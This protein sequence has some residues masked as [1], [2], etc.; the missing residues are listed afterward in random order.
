MSRVLLLACVLCSGCERDQAPAAVVVTP[1]PAPAPVIEPALPEAD[2]AVAEPAPVD[3]LTELAALDQ[4]FRPAPANTHRFGPGGSHAHVAWYPG[5]AG[6]R[7]FVGVL[8]STGH[9]QV[10]AFLLEQADEVWALGRRHA[11]SRVDSE[12]CI[13]QLGPERS[14]SRTL[15]ESR[16]CGEAKVLDLEGDGDVEVLSRADGKVTLFRERGGAVNEVSGTDACA[17]LDGGC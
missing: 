9:D 17:L 1:A 15:V 14:D 10:K 6:A 12:V 2:A 5:S 11:V 3:F 8:F 4:A 13:W 7:S 16:W